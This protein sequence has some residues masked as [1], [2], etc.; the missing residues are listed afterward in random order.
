MPE[1]QDGPPAV[2]RLKTFARHPRVQLTLTVLAALLLFVAL[3]FPNILSRLTPLG[4]LRIPLE[5][6]VMV[7]LLVVLPPRARRVFA[8][9]AGAL[10]GLLVIEK[11]LD[12]GFFEELNRPFDPVL[13]WVLFD[14]AFSFVVDSYG[15]FAAIAAVAVIVLLVVGVL[16]LT[17]WSV[18][19]VGALVGRH[20]RK[21]AITAGGVGVAWALTFSLGVSV[22]GAVPVAARSTATYAWDRAHQARAGLRDEAEFAKEVQQDPFKTVPPAQMLTGLKGKDVIFTFVESYGRSAVEGVALAPTVTPVLDRGTATLAEAGFTARSGWLTSPTFGGG[23]WLAHATFE[24]GL[25]I[26]NEQRYRNLVATDRLTLTRAFRDANYRTV[27]VM[28]GA[29][30][31]WPEGN[32]YGY[33]TVWDSRNLGY[34][35]PKFS[36]SPMPDQ[37]TLKQ[38]NTIE[39]KKAG[40]GPLMVEMPLVSSHTPWAPIP[41]YLPD[42]NQVG[43]GSIYHRMVEGAKKPSALWA[44]PREVRAEYGKSIVYSLTALINWVR[45][46]GDDDLVMVFLG[47]HQPSPIAAG[48]GASHDVPVT[49]LAKDPKALDRIAS[50]GWTEG[51]RPRPDAP[52]WPMNDFRNKFFTAFGEQTPAS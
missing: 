23:S 12:M 31:A 40:R 33:D 26:N 13:D 1:I 48:A 46:Y 18:L 45:L 17:C 36:W 35:G 43:D 7:G 2:G 51:L 41:D 42:W 10:V 52:V 24:S 50:W 14:D 28:P 38:L 37:Y 5:G 8:I 29:T 30:R 11:C 34:Q 44:E 32:F 9:A 49:V 39:Y 15:R 27:S 19:R 25:W 20:R 16:A 21:S 22:W 6:A 3:I 4:F 47:D